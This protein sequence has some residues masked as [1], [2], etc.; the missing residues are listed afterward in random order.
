MTAAWTVDIHVATYA[1]LHDIDYLPMILRLFHLDCSTS[2]HQCN[3][4]HPEI[5]LEL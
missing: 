4:K 1:P 2:L 3:F 5:A